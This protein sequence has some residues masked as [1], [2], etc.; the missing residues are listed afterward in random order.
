[1][2]RLFSNADLKALSSIVALLLLLSSIPSAGG[3][4]VIPSPDQPQFTVNICQPTQAF[5]CTSNTP[6]A[7]PTANAPQFALCSLISL[8]VKATARTVERDVP[9][10]TPPP[11]R[12]V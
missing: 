9:P 4:V 8:T 1:M 7:R 3:I 10:D 12:S 2:W 11:K 5:N 6:L